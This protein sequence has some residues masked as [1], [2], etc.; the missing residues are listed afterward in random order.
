MAERMTPAELHSNLRMFSGTEEAHRIG[1]IP[2]FLVSDGVKYLADKGECFWLLDA[3]SSYYIDSSFRQKLDADDRLKTM[4]FWLLEKKGNGAVLKC[5]RDTG[6][7]EE[8]YVTQDIPS[9]DF[10]FEQG[11]TMFKIYVAFTAVGNRHVYLAM[12]PSEY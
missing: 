11:E 7:G 5:Q 3:I 9:T 10:P 6:P 12:L 2:N 4:Q 1:I 8:A